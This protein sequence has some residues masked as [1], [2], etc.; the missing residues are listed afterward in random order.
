MTKSEPYQIKSPDG[1]D[2]ADHFI[3]CAK[4]GRYLTVASDTRFFITDDFL[5]GGGGG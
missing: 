1:Y 2:L 3:A 5:G 4:L